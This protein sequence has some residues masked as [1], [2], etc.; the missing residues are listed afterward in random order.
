VRSLDQSLTGLIQLRSYGWSA[1]ALGGSATVDQAAPGRYRVLVGP[2]AD[3]GTAERSRRAV[4]S[5]GYPDATM[6][7]GG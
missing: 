6:I 3:A 2:W 7:S 1:R 5:R 4:I